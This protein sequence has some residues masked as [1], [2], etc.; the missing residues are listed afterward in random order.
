MKL[1]INKIQD[2]LEGDWWLHIH[3]TNFGFESGIFNLTDHDVEKGDILIHKKIKEGD[4]FPTIRYHKITDKGTTNLENSEVKELLTVKLVDY[5]R[6]SKKLP[7]GCNVVKFFKNG[8]A[9]V[10]YKPSDYDN[11][12]LKIMPKEHG[13]NNTEE[14]LKDLVVSENPIKTEVSK[15]PQT[16]GKQW[17]IPSSSDPDKKYIVKYTEG[18]SWSCSCPQFTFRRSECKHIQECKKKVII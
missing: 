3:S 13:V 1:N 12:S 8:A 2:D 10:N 16:Q 17:E 15:T 6:K 9:Q 5:I 4:R 11:F 7:Y 18:G 14:F